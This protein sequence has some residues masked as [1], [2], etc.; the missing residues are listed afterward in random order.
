MTTL[1]SRRRFLRIMALASGGS[2]LAACTPTA[3]GS[4][5]AQP[6]VKPTEA[7]KPVASSPESARPAVSPVAAASPAAA[8][9]SGIDPSL[10]SVWQGKTVTLTVDSPAGSAGD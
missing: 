10:A 8:Q 4:P 5:T 1:T 3:P 7:A 2:L 6:A 9:A